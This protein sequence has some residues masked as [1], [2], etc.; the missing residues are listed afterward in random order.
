MQDL[1]VALIQCPLVWE[2]PKVNLD[3][4]SNRLKL[5]KNKPDLIIL[6]E[7]FS[8][9]FTMN[10]QAAEGMQGT[11]ISWL[12]AESAKYQSIITGSVFITENGKF[13]NRLIWMNPDGTFD[14]YDKRHLFRMGNESD[15]MTAGTVRKIMECNGWKINLQICYDLRFP[16][17]SINHFHDE[18]YD[19]DVLLYVANWP[20]IRSHAYKALLIARAIENQSYVIWVNRIGNDGKGIGHSGDSMVIDP[21]GKVV[22]L[23]PPGQDLILPAVLERK[24]LNNY[25]ASFRVGLDWDVFYF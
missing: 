14:Y 7:M 10:I 19:Y 1:T 24:L 2:N 4:L 13:Y 21:H 23:A 25:R 17:W 22:A 12:R 9:G 6:P 11:A 15:V 8:T 16:A 5:G 3:G 18:K 20:E